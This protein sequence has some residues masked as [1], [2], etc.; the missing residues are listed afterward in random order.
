MGFHIS[1]TEQQG[2]YRYDPSTVA[3][4]G[5]AR[6]FPYPGL[7]GTLRFISTQF[8]QL[9]LKRGQLSQPLSL[10]LQPL[11]NLEHSL[12]Q[13][14]SQITA[15]LP[16]VE[17]FQ[18]NWLNFHLPPDE[19]FTTEFARERR[20][21]LQT[22]LAARQAAKAE[23]ADR[24]RARN[25]FYQALES[26]RRSRPL[27]AWIYERDGGL[28]DREFARQRVA[29]TNP[30]VIRR[31]WQTDQAALQSW[32]SETTYR[33][34]GEPLDLVQAA[35][36]NRLFLVDYPILKELTSAELQPGRYVG[37]PTAVFYQGTQGLEPV[38]IQRDSGRIVQPQDGAD[39]WMRAK[40]WVQTAD[41]TH[42]EL[43]AHLADTH[44]AMEVFAVATPRQLPVNHP[45]YRLLR[46]HLQ[47]LLAINTRGNE[48]L[49]SE[50]GAIDQL[51]APTR[52]ASLR[53][54]N[55]AYRDRP[56]SDY[57]LPKDLHRRGVEADVLPDFPYR[58]DARLLWEAIERYVSR[59]LQRYYRDDQA[60]T[61]DPYLSAWAAE[62]GAPL[63]AQRCQAEFPLVPDWLPPSLLTE[64]GLVPKPS[65]SYVR[66]PQFPTRESAGQISSLQQLVDVVT[67][68]IFTCA[69]QHAAV[70]FSQFDYVGYAPNAPLALYAHPEAD[71]PLA[72][73]MPSTAQELAQMELVFALTGIRWGALGSSEQIQFHDA[74]DRAVLQEFQATLR[75]IEATINSRNQ[76]RLSR[77]GVDYPYLLPS[78]IPNSINI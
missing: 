42:H 9:W 49:L 21:M 15:L 76:E 58:D 19:Q 33:C 28:R 6:L 37:S 77:T 47:F 16:D 5:P 68:V 24:D 8:P 4:A 12:N 48:V 14:W 17:L 27:V 22:L 11:E 62:L 44:L 41:V 61:S 10:L 59:F 31:L 1:P 72:A 18:S 30:M 7:D 23:A 56:F 3:Q 60:V 36:E 51:L 57:A 35:A 34:D 40:L 66:V 67:Q 63:N 64:V 71:Q 20:E 38:L 70:N 74:G 2:Q 46:P 54:I 78:R 26:D 69:P 75:T 50:R 65:P 13:S 25:H 32:A 43:I 53:L 52:E 45:V 29:G 73:M 39:D 55:K